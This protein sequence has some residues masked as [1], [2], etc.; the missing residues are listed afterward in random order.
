MYRIF[1][2]VF[3]KSKTN[4]CLKEVQ[5]YTKIKNIQTIYYVYL[6]DK[7]NLYLISIYLIIYKYKNKFFF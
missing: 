6:E 2:L 1:K 5:S 4:K 3:L 7:I